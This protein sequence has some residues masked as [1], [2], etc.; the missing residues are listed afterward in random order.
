M[1]A[2]FD[3]QF[4][5][6]VVNRLLPFP[7]LLKQVNGGRYSY[8][9]KCFCC[10]HNNFD[11]PAAKIYHNED[12]DYMFCFSEQ[13]QYR[14]SDVFSKKL[15]NRRLDQVFYKLWEQ[16]S[17][18]VQR[19]LMEEQGVEVDRVPQKWKDNKEKLELF[20]KGLTTIDQHIILMANSLE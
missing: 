1:E 10:F 6:Y 4:M 9:R 8:D 3:T 20:K 7:V 2:T 15:L 17:S 19:M 14:P 11:T 12:G 18:D 16:L 5:E 13:R